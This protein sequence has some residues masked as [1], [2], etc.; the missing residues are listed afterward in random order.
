MPGR[1]KNNFNGVLQHGIGTHAHMIVWTKF[2]CGD[3]WRLL[4][5]SRKPSNIYINEHEYLDAWSFQNA[6]YV[7]KKML[8]NLGMFNCRKW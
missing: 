2:L 3:L 4:W 5:V 6:D 7:F 1:K 8:K